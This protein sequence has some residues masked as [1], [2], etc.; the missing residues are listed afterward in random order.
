MQMFCPGKKDV[1]GNPFK[2][3][4]ICLQ[5]CNLKVICFASFV[6]LKDDFFSSKGVEFNLFFSNIK[7]QGWSWIFTMSFFIV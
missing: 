1:K 4:G 7:K 3:D 5:E 6:R 2:R